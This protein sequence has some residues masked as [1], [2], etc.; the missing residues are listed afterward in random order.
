MAVSGAIDFT[1]QAVVVTGAGRGLGRLYAIDLAQ[2]GA[3]VVVNDL[4]GAMGG[5]G[6]DA[7]VADS[8]VEEIRAAGGVAV[9][10]HDSVATPDGGEAIIRACVD[11][12]GRV[13]AV[14]SNAGIFDAVRFD[15]MSVDAWRRMLGVHLDGTFHVAQPAYRV[16]KEQQYG[17][18]VLTSSNSGAFGRSGAAHYAAA[19]MGVVGLTNAIAIE[20]AR[21]GILANAVLPLA[22]T[23]MV[24][25]T[26][27]LD[28]LPAG[29]RAFFDAIVPERA[30]AMVVYLASRACDVTHHNY[31]AA[32]GRFAR[33]FVGLGAGWFAGEGVTPTA[34]DVAAHR[35]EIDA[36]DDH[37]VPYGLFDEAAQIRERLGLP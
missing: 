6:A 11:A 22:S 21:H 3:Q 24:H 31:S 18:F 33:V 13:D 10:S 26:V 15:E 19:K 29:E 4:G 17:R 5:G 25:D 1:G 37:L 23:R 2:R 34:E 8:V 16:M 27:S 35:E 14:V 36:L 32:A 7:G 9:A 12:F 20:G 30:V 28:E